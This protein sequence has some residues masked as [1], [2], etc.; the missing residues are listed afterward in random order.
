MKTVKR[1]MVSVASTGSTFTGTFARSFGGDASG[2]LGSVVGGP[3]P[4]ESLSDGSGSGPAP[5]TSPPETTAEEIYEATG[6]EG[7]LVVHVGCGD[8][9]LT[10][11][12]YAGEAY[13][14]HGLDDYAVAPDGSCPDLDAATGKTV[15]TY[16]ATK[17]TEELILSDG[18]LF[19]QVREPPTF[20]PR[21]IP[22]NK[23]CQDEK[24]YVADK[25][26][27]QGDPREV[28]AVEAATGDVLWK[29]RDSVVPLTLAADDQSV[30]YHDGDRV[31]CL[32]RTTG[33]ET[34]AS[35]PVAQ[36]W[37]VA[38]K[39]GGVLVA[40]GDHVLYVGSDKPANPSDNFA[41]TITALNRETGEILW[42][43]PHLEGGHNS[44]DDL[45]VLN[46]QVW[47][48]QIANTGSSG[49]FRGLNLATGNQ[50]TSFTPDVSPSWM[51]HRC[52]RAKA[53]YNYFL[54]SRMGIEFIDVDEDASPHWE[55]HHWTRGGCL[56]GVMPANGM[57]YNPPHDC[58]CYLQSKTFG[59]NALAPDA[60]TRPSSDELPSGPGT[61]GDRLEE[62]PAYDDE[63]ISG[64]EDP[65]VDWP[66][67]RHDALRS[68]STANAVSSTLS[69]L[70]RQAVGGR[71][72]ALAVAVEQRLIKRP[73]EP[74]PSAAPD[75]EIVLQNAAEMPGRRITE[76]LGL[77]QGHTVFAIWLGKDLSALV[78]LILG[79]ELTEYTEMM[80]Q[81]RT[82]AAN[83]M[84]AQA[85]D[86]GADAII[87]V[88]YMTTSV[89]GSA[90]ELLVYGT[91]VKL[92]E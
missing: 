42:S 28:V 77:V 86:L 2:T 92:G 39:H 50:Q 46:D 76:V 24:P 88:R 17:A 19:C 64:S 8:A 32:D 84:V 29:V 36:N 81:A 56:Y 57:V 6:V 31:V 75:A 21:F 66:T 53:T 51:H 83:R 67:Y 80:G 3:P 89:V 33:K 60:P 61:T 18:V 20:R 79:G 85:A 7:G 87:N 45:F 73:P 43:A 68:G 54:A 37:Q 71:L 63:T 30:Y 82:A 44:A 1:G 48:A 9:T 35:A 23:R 22:L 65:A 55:I 91:A 10:A 58:A 78:R 49:E 16:G 12:L 38:P 15:R 52:H 25:W 27:W 34:W 11:D 41:N 90:A 47:S 74:A 14:V 4:V 40:Y 62:G 13:R 69:P 72:S 5:L 59:F 70:W 26:A